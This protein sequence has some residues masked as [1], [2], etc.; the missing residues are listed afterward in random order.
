MIA[1][2]LRPLALGLVLAA[3]LGEAVVRLQGEP[4]SARPGPPEPPLARPLETADPRLY[5]LVPGRVSLQDFSRGGRPSSVSYA[6]DA[7]G[8]RAPHVDWEPTPGAR[9]VA[10]LGDSFVFGT[11]VSWAESLPAQLQARLREAGLEDVE[12]LNRG[13]PGYAA[14]QYPAL[15]QQVDEH[16]AVVLVVYANDALPAGLPGPETQA[17]PGTPPWWSVSALA[18]RLDA[19]AGWAAR[20]GDGEHVAWLAQVWGAGGG[21][22]RVREAVEA[23]AAARETVV[24]AYHPPLR[25]SA[26]RLPCARILERTC[27]DL[28]VPFVDLG[29]ALAGRP[30]R[31][32]WVHPADAH[33][34]AE[35]HGLTA[36]RLAPP[37]IDVLR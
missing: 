17:P 36:A 32:L 2:A 6:V 30:P 8:R 7:A 16:A 3:G 12:V 19:A 26:E 31:S 21:E 10:V 11:G 27:A 35:A 15:L 34:T 13:V 37:L 28:G 24:V 20:R 22:R 4:A 23:V 14:E 9:Q 25:W 33:P 18:R 1:R 5:E 29:P